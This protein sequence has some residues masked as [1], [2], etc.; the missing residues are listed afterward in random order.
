MAEYDDSSDAEYDLLVL[1]G[2]P[3]GVT[4]A[5]YAKRYNLNVALITLEIGGL[6]NEASDV[7]N[8]PG[9]VKMKGPEICEK[10]R[11]HLE[12][13]NVKVILENVIGLKK[14]KS[15]FKVI[16]DNRDYISKAIIF[17]VG[18]KHRKLEL[19]EI[20]RFEGRGVS[21]C[22]TCDGPFFK[23]KK[24]GVVGG[25][26]SAGRAVQLLLQQASKVYL[27]HRG[28]KNE[29]KMDPVLRDEIFSN[30]KL[31]F[32]ENSNVKQLIGEKG[33]KEIILDNGKT[34]E[35][36][37]LFIEIGLIPQT[38]LAKGIGV[39]LDSYNHIVVDEEMKTN[40]Q[41]F[42]AAGDVT[43]KNAILRQAVTASAQGA[44]AAQSAF[45]YLKKR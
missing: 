41:G 9:F 19:P 29:L 35:M 23:N 33:L 15:N 34:I 43:D 1:G 4:A 6:I 7:D 37:G 25:G 27:I 18:N 22:A 20:S 13:L 11:E 16:T 42:F 38:E 8:W 21:Y 24:V 36:E 31:E 2:G 14:E 40:V 44:I 17:A 30:K 26:N 3:A 32:I 12:Y 10:L 45:N 28:T 39:K 5:I